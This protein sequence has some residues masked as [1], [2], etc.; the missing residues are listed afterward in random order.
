MIDTANITAAQA[1]EIFQA[2]A[3]G[4]AVEW[5]NKS[6]SPMATWGRDESVEDVFESIKCGLPM[7]I[8]KFAEQCKVGD[9]V[10]WVWRVD[11]VIPN[12]P[13]DESFIVEGEGKITGIVSNEDGT[14][15]LA[16]VLFADD[17]MGANFGPFLVKPEQLCEVVR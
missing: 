5:Q 17:E 1:A 15:L 8:R 3:D 10:K 7:R 11:L 14:G 2:L 4:H 12:A 16:Y 6:I 13:P 9:H